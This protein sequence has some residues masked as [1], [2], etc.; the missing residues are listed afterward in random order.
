MAQGTVLA[1]LADRFLLPGERRYDLAEAAG[2]AGASVAEVARLW[3]ALGF[4]YAADGR[5]LFTDDDVAIFHTV[6]ADSSMSDAFFHEARLLSGALANV[7]EVLVD[8]MWDH[9]VSEGGPDAAI[10]ELAAAGIDIPRI[11]RILL[12]IL[13]RQLVAAVYR[14][15]TVHPPAGADTGPMVAIGFADLVGFTALSQRVGP[16]ELARLVM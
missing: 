12:H 3:R 6:V 4:P 14:R 1:L 8:E 10:G 16:S 9:H 11:E 5:K 15:A 13:R 2:E 7:A